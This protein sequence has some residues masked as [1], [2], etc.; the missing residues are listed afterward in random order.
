MTNRRTV[1]KGLAGL[2]VAT[3]LENTATGANAI[4]PPPAEAGL[5]AGTASSAEWVTLPGKAPLIK[6]TFRPPNLETPL[7]YFRDPITPNKAFFVRYHHAN[8]PA[9]DPATWTLRVGGPAASQKVTFTLAQLRSQ[10]EM[11]DIT[12]LCL[13]SGNRRGLFAPHVGGVQWG[14]GAMGNA[15]W[16][17]VRLGDVLRKAGVRPDALEVAF[18]GSDS[19]VMP[20]GPD[21][22]KSLPV[23]KAL[24]SNTLIALEMNG[25]Q[26]PPL[27]GAPAR[28]VVPGWTATYWIKHLASIEL[29][30]APFDNFW[31][32][33]GYRIPT[34]AFPGLAT[35]A[36]QETTANTP[37][38]EIAINS[39]I[40]T[41][42]PAAP[43]A[44]GAA[45]DVRGMAW[46]GGHGLKRV[47]WSLNRGTT[48]NAAQ[49]GTD[50]GPFS[51][52]PWSFNAPAPKQSGRLSVWVRATSRNGGTQ[53]L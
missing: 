11:V 18:D 51:L 50:H 34:G 24:D 28:L 17:G 7:G 45:I 43:L 3:A 4:A 31:V 13:C 25:E 6:R 15:R 8:I 27:H 23:A 20:G 21:Y 32:K 10:F 42:A 37:I 16:R 1:V 47:E 30:N 33:T 12:A 35:F 52:R 38:T 49:L 41:P 5:A 14:S 39:L 53:P 19:P 9:V 2:A 40:T 36:S 29:L 46:D 26:L 48:W 22:Q 44:P